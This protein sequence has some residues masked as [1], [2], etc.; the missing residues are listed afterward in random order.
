MTI[1]AIETLY[2]GYRFRSRLEARWAVFFDALGIKYKYEEYGFEKEV[3]D[4]EVYRWLPDFYL[5]DLG[6][7]VEV[8]GGKPSLKDAAKMGKLLDYGS[9]LP[10]FNESDECDANLYSRKFEGYRD[11][12]QELGGEGYHLCRG[13]L[14]LGEIPHV[15]HGFVLH[16]LITHYKGL[17]RRCCEFYSKWLARKTDGEINLI[18]RFSGEKI[19]Q[20]DDYLDGYID[21]GDRHSIGFFTPSNHVFETK[22]ARPE[23]CAAYQKARSAR[24]EHGENKSTG[25]SSK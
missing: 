7:W 18:E 3:F 24:F 4:G 20:S 11:E 1:K 10:F 8:K 13:V 19:S 22:L 17:H 15:N 9:P 14:L 2:K 25:Q 23:V 5:P 6:A 21:E 16:P 12:Y